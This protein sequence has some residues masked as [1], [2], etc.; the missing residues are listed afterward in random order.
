[1]GTTSGP[2]NPGNTPIGKRIRF[3]NIKHGWKVVLI[4]ITSRAAK[5]AEFRIIEGVID[6]GYSK[7]TIDLEPLGALPPLGEVDLWNHIGV[8]AAL[9]VWTRVIEDVHE[10]VVRACEVIVGGVEVIEGNA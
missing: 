3:L 5:V 8:V 1:V 7:F 6:D 10:T 4:N 9:A 2:I